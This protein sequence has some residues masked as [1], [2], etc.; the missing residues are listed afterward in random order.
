MNIIS[1]LYRMVYY[2]C[3]ILC[4]LRTTLLLEVLE[5]GHCY[6]N[7]AVVITAVETPHAF[8][9]RMLIYIVDVVV[10]EHA[11]VIGASRFSVMCFGAT[12]RVYNTS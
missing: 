9:M 12:E 8:A 2:T 7:K 1:E 11:R 3:G 4:A 10:I 5:E 6:E